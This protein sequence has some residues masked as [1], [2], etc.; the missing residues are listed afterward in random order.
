MQMFALYLFLH[1]A[2]LELDLFTLLSVEE[3]VAVTIIIN[4]GGSVTQF[5]V[6][7]FFNPSGKLLTHWKVIVLNETH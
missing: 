1:A 5:L 4:N 3:L 7:I 6:V 2:I